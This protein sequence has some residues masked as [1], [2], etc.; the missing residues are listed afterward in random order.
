MGIRRRALLGLY[1]LGVTLAG[2]PASATHAEVHP[3]AG[4]HYTIY[5]MAGQSNMDGRGRAEDLEGDL[6]EFAKPNENVLVRFSSGGYKRRHRQSQGFVP[7]QPGINEKPGQFGPELGFGHALAK[8]LPKQNILIVKVS[9]GGT[10][11]REDWNPENRKSLY[12]RLVATCKKTCELLTERGAT[13]EFGGMAW[14]QGESDSNRPEEYPARLRS[15][16]DRLR[17]DVKAPGMPLVV[18]GLCSDNPKYK[19]FNDAMQEFAASS[20]DIGFASS[21]RLKAFDKNVHFDAR[22]QIELGQRMAQAM[23]KLQ[24]SE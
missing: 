23:L 21:D 9:E 22:S 24:R 5:L 7:L 2:V 11:L 10:S 1:W 15:F 12:H 16:L 19:G 3:E 18:G 8:A 17:A 13:Y 14:H 6:A 20:D 4:K